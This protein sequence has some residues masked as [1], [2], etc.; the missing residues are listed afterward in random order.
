[1]DARQFIGLPSR[2]GVSKSVRPESAVLSS[3]G[4]SDIDSGIAAVMQENRS[5]VYDSKQILND[6]QCH[7][8]L[9]KK[10][11]MVRCSQNFTLASQQYFS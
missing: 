1:M 4:H 2:H 5:D 8:C 10:E 7:V 6:K 11:Q 3:E 9:R